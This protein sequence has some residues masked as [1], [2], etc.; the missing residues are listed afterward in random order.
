MSKFIP[1]TDDELY[2]A[3]HADIKDY[4]ESVG[5]KVRRSGTEYMW[6]SHDSVKIRG[7]IWYR[8]STG[9]SGTAVTFL[10]TFFHFSYQDAIITLLNGNYIASSKTRPEDMAKMDLPIIKHKDSKIILPPKN[11]DNKRLYAYLCNYRLLSYAVV[12]Y[13]VT[14]NLIYEEKNNHNI[15]FLCRD[16]KG[17]VKYAGMKGTLSDK[18][19]RSE[20]YNSDKK[21][22]FRHV[23]N[24]D[25]LY[26]FEAFIDMF[27]YIDLFLKD[28]DDWKNQN[29]LAMGGLIYPS[30]RFFI[31][32]YKN[33]KKIVLCTDND[34]YSNDGVNH[35]QKFADKA[36]KLLSGEFSV[37][38][39]VPYKKDW[40]EDLM[41]YKGRY[42]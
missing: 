40:N 26:V 8:F 41:K 24:S 11:A 5:E 31:D 21:Y 6:E 7:H 14:K 9:D 13:F 36:E 38:R 4:L 16:K 32:N 12:N 39:D 3:H 2:R 10:Q 15:V 28:T 25:T 37:R 42:K 34:C 1:F 19:F 33:I 17:Y 27:S 22:G 35:G 20:L 30:I 18:P 23:G 29:Y